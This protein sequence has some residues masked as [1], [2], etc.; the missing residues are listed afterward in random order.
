MAHPQQQQQQQQQGALTPEQ[1]ASFREKG[2]LVLPGAATVQQC[3]ALKA[4]MSELLT[5]FDVDAVRSI[6]S[7]RNQVS[8]SREPRDR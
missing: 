5:S 7:T 3:E 6:F 4:R 1:V 8:M 2:F